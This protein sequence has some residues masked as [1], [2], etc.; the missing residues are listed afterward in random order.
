MSQI[1]FL[2]LQMRGTE[3]SSRIVERQS[4]LQYTHLKP[5]ELDTVDLFEHPIIDP[6]IIRKYD[7][8]LVG[9]I[10]KDLPTELTWP[11]ERFPFIDYLYQLLHIA[12]DE[13]IPS[14]LSCGGYV[15][16]ADM[17]GAK[18]HARLDG[19]EIGVYNMIKTQDAQLDILL[20]G[21]PNPLP[22]VVGH[23]KYFKTTPPNTTLLLY[24]DTYSPQVPV[25]AF[26]VNRAPFYAFQGHPEISCSDLSGRVKPPMYRKHYFPPRPG[27]A[28]DCE[29]GYNQEAYQ[30]FCALEQDT[31]ASQSLLKTF[32]DLV[33]QGA[34]S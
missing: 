18:M 17:L 3:D 1:K 26:K 9:G 21:T 19:F 6:T 24:T 8:L 30:A 22:M 31:S 32:V 5:E 7:G 20:Q 14:L 11:K 33:R 34:L 15:I 10:S 12:I 2:L 4:Y 23:I 27:H 16:A 25:Q 13:K 29:M 28:D